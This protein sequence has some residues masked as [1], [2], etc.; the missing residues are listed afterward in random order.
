MGCYNQTTVTLH[1]TLWL[2]ETGDSHGD[3]GNITNAE[4]SIFW[5]RFGPIV[6]LSIWIMKEP[7]V[8]LG[9]TLYSFVGCV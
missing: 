2:Y 5:V 1:F 8:S 9:L 3:I 4:P 7:I 6:S